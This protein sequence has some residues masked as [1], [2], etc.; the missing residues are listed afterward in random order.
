MPPTTNLQPGQSGQAVA[1][2][3]QF[4]KSQGLLT[5]AQIASGPGVYGPQTTAAV[6]AWQAKNGI[7]NTSGPGYWGPKSIAKATG[8]GSVVED[9]AT[10]DARYREAAGKNPVIAN[11]TKGGS[12]LE[13]IVNG[14]STGDLS[15]LTD[16]N[17]M[18]FSAEDQHAALAQADADTKLYYDALKQKE[19]AD[20]EAALAAKTA[21]YQDYLLK[22][23]QNFQ[24]DKTQ[25]DQTAANQGVLFSGGR[26]QKEK[27]LERTYAQDNATKFRNT[28][29]DIG[30]LGS[31][32]QYKYGNDS[33]NSLSKY[34][35]LGGNT[36]NANVATGG[37][38]SNGL[39]SI[40]NPSQYNYQGTQNVARKAAAA[41]RA[42][43][44][45][46]NKG[47]KL[48]A[49]GYNNQA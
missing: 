15:G 1:Q 36:Y 40:Y 5:D 4:L 10:V 35:N 19:T 46:W 25:L 34:Y 39:S 13:Q 44:L 21:D 43:G 22:S 29:A 45:L 7:D 41:T 14:L 23:G 8:Q 12:S 37:V 32:Y 3:Q 49:S 38:T 9:Q 30:A 24:E 48:V 31:D 47:N 11:L 17:G 27:N 42:A 16:A 2:L 6:K 26:V 20:T 33:A 28:S 18:P